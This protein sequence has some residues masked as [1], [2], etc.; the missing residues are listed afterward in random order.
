MTGLKAQNENG[1]TKCINS[2]TSVILNIRKI[3][4]SILYVFY[5]LIKYYPKMK[6]NSK[7]KNTVYGQLTF[8]K[9][10]KNTQWGRTLFNTWCWEKWIRTHRRM[11]LDTYLKPLTKNN[12]KRITNLEDVKP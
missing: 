10:T 3:N 5:V 12:S 7:F 4:L 11:K 6:N 8:G 9:S 2:E 1:R